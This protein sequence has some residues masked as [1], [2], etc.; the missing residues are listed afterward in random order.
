MSLLNS[1]GSASLEAILEKRLARRQ[2]I[3]Q[4][5][6]LASG[7]LLAAMGVGCGSSG[8]K[9]A[10]TEVPPAILL[11]PNQGSRLGFQGVPAILDPTFDSIVVPSG[12][13]FRP[14]F[15]WGDEV[16]AGAP[17]WQKDASDTAEAQALQAGQSHDGMIF[18][19]LDGR[20]DRGLLVMNFE[21]IEPNTIHKEGVSKDAAGRRPLTQVRKEQAALGV[22]VIEV[23]RDAKGA[24]QQK[25]NS[26]YGRRIDLHTRME[27]RGPAAGHSKLQTSEDQS[28]R[29]VKGT[30]NNCASSRTPWGTYLTCEE[31]FQNYFAN[32]DAAALARTREQKRYGIAASTS[33]GWETVDPRFEA[34][35]KGGFANEANR[36]GWVVE[37]DP[38]D[39]SS[40]PIKHTSFGRFSHENCECA[41]TPDGRLAFYMGDDARAEYIYKFVPK[42]RYDSSL[43]LA[44]SRL[45]EE[46]TLYV[47]V[48]NEDGTGTWKALAFGQ[49][50]L[51]PENGFADQADVLI[52]AR[53]AADFVGA[54]SMDRPE[55]VA[56]HPESREIYV[57]LTNNNKR[58]NGDKRQALNPA[59]PRANN[60]YGHILHFKEEGNDPAAESFRWD[61]F[62]SAGDPAAADPQQRGNVQGDSFGSPDGLYIDQGGRLWICTDFDDAAP[63][64]ANIGLNQLLCADPETREV[65]RFLVGPKGC[66]ITGIAHSPDKKAMFVNIQHPLLSFPASDGQSRPR[67]TTLVI[68]KDDGGEIGS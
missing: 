2:L 51:T 54:T 9:A 32:K 13:Q 44:N 4:G 43:G 60:V 59:N 24:W 1:F 40:T 23:Q 28:G 5:L 55:W 37:I 15:S 19:A 53:S 42:G 10:K 17:A 20:E 63:E 12:Y 25:K 33:Y 52:N 41:L 61:I 36:F 26:A 38:Y 39:P 3:G 68:T 18:Y 65:R 29:W 27:I 47:A 14:L 56:V 31:N 30:L 16:V 62:L 22:G 45:L 64:Y 57:T 34:E 67:S 21:D 6:T 35:P 7:G 58:G 46:G 11:K 66:E 8:S 50:G 49:N 48:C